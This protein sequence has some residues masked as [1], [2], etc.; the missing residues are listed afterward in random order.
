MQNSSLTELERNYK[1][2][3]PRQWPIVMKI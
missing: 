2:S 3:S 1:Q